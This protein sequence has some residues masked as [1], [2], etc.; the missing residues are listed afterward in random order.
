MLPTIPSPLV[1]KL[2]PTVAP[3]LNSKLERRAPWSLVAW[4]LTAGLLWLLLLNF[5]ARV[6]LPEQDSSWM[7]VMTEA[8]V[9][10]WRFGPE[11][12]FTYGP[13]AFL[14][15]GTYAPELFWTR[16]IYQIIAKAF[17]VTVVLR[18]AWRLPVVDRGVFLGLVVCNSLLDPETLLYVTTSWETLYF[19]TLV[20]LG[21]LF[22]QDTK[23]SRFDRVLAWSGLPFAASASLMKSTYLVLSL[24]VLGCVILNGWVRPRERRE[25]RWGP[26]LLFVA[27]FILF[28]VSW[29]QKLGDLPGYLLGAADIVVGYASMGYR[30]DTLPL[31][32]ALLLASAALIQLVLLWARSPDRR[33]GLT[34][35]ALL[36]GGLLMAW[37]QGFT[38]ADAFHV[39]IFISYVVLAVAMTPAFFIQGWSPLWHRLTLVATLCAAFYA[40]DSKLPDSWERMPS[41]LGQHLLRNSVWLFWPGEGRREMDRIMTNQRDSLALPKVQAAVG[42][43]TVGVFGYEQAIAILNELNFRPAPM[44]QGYQVNTPRLAAM[45]AVHYRSE[46]APEYVLFKLQATDD[47]IPTLDDATALPELWL[48]YQ[49]VLVEHDY[50]LLR[51][52]AETAASTPAIPG[53]L[54]VGGQIALN[55]PVA[56]PSTGVFWLELEIHDSFLGKLRGFFYHRPDV[57]LRTI[58]QEQGVMTWALPPGMAR[59]GFM[60]GPGLNSLADFVQLLNGEERGGRIRG[61]AVHV[62]PGDR[63]WLAPEI[64]YHLYEL[65]PPLPTEQTVSVAGEDLL[66]QASYGDLFSPTPAYFHAAMPLERFSR[67]GIPFVRVHPPG[68]MDFPVPAGATQIRAD[69]AYDEKVFKPGAEI[70]GTEFVI[71]WE[72]GDGQPP[73]RLFARLLQPGVVESHRAAQH[74]EVNLPPGLPS[75]GHLVLRTLREPGGSTGWTWA[76]W[77]RVEIR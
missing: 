10:G 36:A 41:R 68:R 26:S 31:C 46:R 52:V 54:L 2:P 39:Q 16:W 63:C 40:L 34:R 14:G 35:V 42:R 12:I 73:T 4:S 67:D 22:C 48:R 25:L 27:C 20:L 64:T 72:P 32:L 18:V 38:R 19:L 49:P 24:C 74:V 33:M 3:L 5:T 8:A 71:D 37:K 60:I 58:S 47:R 56:L 13:L 1:L 7:T 28:W 44:I 29:G 15:T 61:F 69:Y 9:R 62:G 75:S 11:V 17:I 30:A 53:R 43:A 45:N 21:L 76:G 6:P 66:A 55:Q 65:T 50:L 57:H 23:F 70:A 51:H 77:G 59:L